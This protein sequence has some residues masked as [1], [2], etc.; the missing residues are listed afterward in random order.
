MIY[1]RTN[2][3]VKFSTKCFTNGGDEDDDEEET[4]AID[5]VMA[6]LPTLQLSS[7]GHC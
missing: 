7:G 1:L 2:A 6:F 4:V 3:S 5:E